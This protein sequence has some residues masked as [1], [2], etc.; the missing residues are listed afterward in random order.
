[1]VWERQAPAWPLSRCPG[2]PPW[3]EGECDEHQHDDAHHFTAVD[4]RFDSL[5]QR[6]DERYRELVGHIEEIYRRLDRLEQEYQAIVE[7]LRRIEATPGD[8]ICRLCRE[9]DCTFPKLTR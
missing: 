8:S 6:I 2:D 4:R 1:M 5:E 9:L 7:A 3:R